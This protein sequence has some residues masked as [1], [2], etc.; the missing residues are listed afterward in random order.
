MTGIYILLGGIALFAVI[1]TTLDGLARRR[2]RR[3]YKRE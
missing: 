2:Q 1:I 3:A